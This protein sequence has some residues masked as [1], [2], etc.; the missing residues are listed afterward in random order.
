VLVEDGLDDVDPADGRAQFALSAIAPL[1]VTRAL[2]PRLKRGAKV[3]L[4]SSRTG[5][6]GDNS[7]GA[8][9][10]TGR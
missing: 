4:I 3:A 6:I 9:T 1:S 2:V 5:S 10:A 7:S 8:I